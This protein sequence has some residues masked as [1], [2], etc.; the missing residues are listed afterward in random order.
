MSHFPLFHSIK[1][2]L[3]ITIGN[4]ACVKILNPMFEEKEKKRDKLS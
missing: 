4:L 2:T 3:N 1:L